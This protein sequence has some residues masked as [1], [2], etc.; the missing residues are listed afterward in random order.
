LQKGLLSSKRL[1][2]KNEENK[3][4]RKASD[5]PFTNSVLF[6]FGIVHNSPKEAAELAKIP[7]Y[8]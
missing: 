4:C 3:N 5:L 2:Q 6:I 8:P 1:L 7:K